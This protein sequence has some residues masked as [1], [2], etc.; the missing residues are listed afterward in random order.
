MQ[1]AIRLAEQ[2]MQTNQGGPFG[3]IIVRNNKI[4]SQGF[5]RVTSTNDPTAHAEI[6][7]IRAACRK[8]KD[9]N[10]SKAALFTSCEPC[11]MCL[12]AIYWA[13]LSKVYYACTRKDAAQIDFADDHIYHELARPIGRRK[14]KFK[15]LLRPAG[16]EIFKKWQKK[17][18]KI[19][20]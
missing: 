2:V 17:A 9:F 12:A 15:Q 14:I 7:A 4:I 11:P 6:V 20:Y 8:I 18:D 10:L 5:N 19:P 16:L 13:K 1:K 3:A